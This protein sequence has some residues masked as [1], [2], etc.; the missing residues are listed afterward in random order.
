MTAGAGHHIRIAGGDI[1]FD[2]RDG[3]TVLGCKAGDVESLAAALRRSELVAL[4]WRDLELVDK[5]LKLTLRHSKTD[6]EGEGQVI[7]VPAGKT[8]KPALRTEYAR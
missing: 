5:G 6:Q 4:E 1:A 2:C 7:A 8:L 3:D